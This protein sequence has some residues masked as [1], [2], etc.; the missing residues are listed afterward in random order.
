VHPAGQPAALYDT[1]GDTGGDDRGWA[2]MM[3][4]TS[5]IEKKLSDWAE[6]NSRINEFGTREYPAFVCYIMNMFDKRVH[7]DEYNCEWVSPYGWVPEG[8]CPLHD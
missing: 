3:T 7:H 8:G 4:I 2:G 1:G 6:A 5:E